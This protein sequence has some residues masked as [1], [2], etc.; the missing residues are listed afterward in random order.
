METNG[1][2]NGVK[3]PIGNMRKK[4]LQSEISDCPLLLVHGKEIF[5][6]NT[7]QQKELIKPSTKS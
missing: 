1:E 7:V 4:G 6:L 5:T 2:R 3:E